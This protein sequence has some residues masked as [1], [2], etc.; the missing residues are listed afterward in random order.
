MLQL[1]VE[2]DCCEVI[3]SS[4]FNNEVVAVVSVRVCVCVLHI[5]F[6]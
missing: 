1:L 4:A 3:N 6:D 5:R 2:A